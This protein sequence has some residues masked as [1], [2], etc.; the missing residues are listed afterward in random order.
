MN[1][2]VEAVVDESFMP[3]AEDIEE[4]DTITVATAAP[5]RKNSIETASGRDWDQAQLRRKAT[6]VLDQVD[7]D[8]EFVREQKRVRRPSRKAAEMARPFQR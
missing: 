7:G 8:I 3:V 2:T 1:A 6:E 4:M 5:V